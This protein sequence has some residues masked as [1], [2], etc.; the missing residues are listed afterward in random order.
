MSISIP[1]DI[2]LYHPSSLAYLNGYLLAS[3]AGTS[4]MAPTPSGRDASGGGNCDT[5]PYPKGPPLWRSSDCSQHPLISQPF[6][7]V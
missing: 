5:S 6:R 3:I 7:Q 1:F 2:M 4:C